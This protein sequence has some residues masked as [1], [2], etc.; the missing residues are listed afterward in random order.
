MDSYEEDYK[1]YERKKSRRSKRRAG[2]VITTIVILAIIIVLILLI[3]NPGFRDWLTNKADNASQGYREYPEWADYDVQRVITI[4]PEDPRFPMD[5]D[6]DLPTPKDIPNATDPWLQD[7]KSVTTSPAPDE[8]EDKYPDYDWMK[9][10]AEDV[11]SSRQI[12]IT[13]SIHTESAVWTVDPSESGT[14]DDIPKWLRDK[15]GN[16][17][18]EEWV[19][20]PDDTQVKALSDQITAGKLT[21]Y[22][23]YKAIFDYLNE[24]YEYQTTRRGEPKFCYE[25]ISSKRGDCDDQSVLFI[26]L[27]RAQGLPSWLEF[28]ALYNQKEKTW[29]GA[30]MGSGVHS[31]LLRRWACI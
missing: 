19:I 22:A 14:V 25:T 31:L 6:V 24:N 20:I 15:Y 8:T 10:K 13:Y 4:S 7:V 2:E 30:C 27:A 23:K 28:G 9:W 3:A 26:S 29:G 1:Y 21:A 16:K 17:T 5:Y 12:S 18:K 11:P